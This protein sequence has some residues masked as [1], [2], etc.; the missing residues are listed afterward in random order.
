MCCFKRKTCL[1][2]FATAR[3]DPLPRFVLPLGISGLALYNR[4]VDDFALLSVAAD[5]VHR[6][7]LVILAVRARGFETAQKQ[8]STPVTEA[9]HQAEALITAGLRAAVRGIPVIAEEEAAAGVTQ[10]RADSFWLVDPLDG[11]REFAA[12]RDEFTVNIG[13]VRDR[14]VVL[15]A[16]ALPAFGE[17]FGGIVAP[18]VAWKRTAAGERP[19]RART[20]PSAGLTVLASRH[21]ASDERLTAFLADRR[22]ASVSHIGSA[23]KIMRVAEG[24]ADLYP[25]FGRTLEWDTA[26]PQAVLEAAG[27]QMIDMAGVPLG[28]GKPGWENPPFICQGL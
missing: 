1:V 4:I 25:R 11:T 17:V 21:Y 9:D 16:V 18:G 8:D 2:A 19:I 10:D 23:V 28:Y 26:G 5:L 12:G 27:G 6:A 13:L 15:G 14:R 22:V 24:V 3:S 20:I 7:S